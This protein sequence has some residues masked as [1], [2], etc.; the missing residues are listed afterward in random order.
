MTKY[1]KLRLGAF[2]ILFLLLV[3]N[4]CF[5][6][7]VL[8]SDINPNSIQRCSSELEKLPEHIR[9]DLIQNW[10]IVVTKQDIPSNF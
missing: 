2:V 6:S 9:K 10:T 1:F 3:A 8:D 4:S 7:V 5:A